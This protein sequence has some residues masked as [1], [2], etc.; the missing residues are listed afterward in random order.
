M[1][2]EQIRLSPAICDSP[3]FADWPLNSMRGCKELPLE[4]R[5]LSIV[6]FPTVTYVTLGTT[7]K[8]TDTACLLDFW[9][10]STANRV[11]Q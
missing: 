8:S 6:A 7:R 5:S 4:R 3:I 10:R 11:N 2:A 1:H 9:V